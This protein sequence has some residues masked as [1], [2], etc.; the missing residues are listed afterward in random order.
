VLRREFVLDPDRSASELLESALDA[1]VAYGAVSRAD[2]AV[3]AADAS[4]AGEV[5]G[6]VRSI[7]E[8]YRHAWAEL[9][10]AVAE[11][12]PADALPAR[13]QKR[14]AARVDRPEACSIVTVQNVVASLREEGVLSVDDDRVAL[15]GRA[16][17]EMLARL[18]PMVDG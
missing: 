10:A 15:R 8:A 16:L 12:P 2:G 18:A 17:T 4:L 11:R 6:T 9:P 14:L 5:L 1:L 3:A 13:L 7:L